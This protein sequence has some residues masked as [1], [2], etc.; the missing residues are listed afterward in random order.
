M[1][2]GSM[3]FIRKF[4][5]SYIL[6]LIL[7]LACFS[8]FYFSY[9]LKIY[10]KNVRRQA[11]DAL[12]TV[13]DELQRTV[14]EFRMI[15][16]QDSGLACTRSAYLNSDMRSEE[17]FALLGRELASH[18]Y[19]ADIT[20]YNTSVPERAY[21]VSGSYEQAYYPAFKHYEENGVDGLERF[22]SGWDAPGW[23][24]AKK[25][26][27][28]D[29]FFLDY[30]VPMSANG[31][32]HIWI[33][34]W[35]TERLQK[36]LESENARTAF[37]DSQDQCLYTTEVEEGLTA[38]IEIRAVSADGEIHLVR[39][40]D[41]KWLFA[42]VAESRNI[43]FSVILLTLLVGS[44]LA[45]FFSMRSSR[46]MEQMEKDILRLEELRR[47]DRLLMELL[48][49]TDG[50]SSDILV[51]L[52]K[53]HMFLKAECYY[54][55]LADILKRPEGEGQE[56]IGERL[57]V[58]ARGPWEL[59]FNG[60]FGE[61]LLVG[62][63]GAVG[64]EADPAPF[65]RETEEEIRKET[66][67]SLAIQAKGPCGTLADIHG[68]Y[69]DAMRM[70]GENTLKEGYFLYPELEMKALYDA[71]LNNE[72]A[73]AG[74]AAD[75]LLERIRDCRQDSFVHSVLC[76]DV[77]R[78]FG[79]TAKKMGLKEEN[80]D[81]LPDWS[82]IS[83]A[84][85][86]GCLPELVKKAWEWT[87]GRLAAQEAESRG[88]R[89]AA[90]VAN[91]IEAHVTEPEISVNQIADQ[92]RMSASNLSHQFKLQTDQN[93]SDYLME[94]KFEYA[95]KLLAK[96]DANVS[97]VAEAIGYIHSGSFI[98]RFRRIYGM[99]PLEYR[100]RCREKDCTPPV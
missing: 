19:L 78:L 44:S 91:Y 7:P 6:L 40:L 57:R 23:F 98:R 13:T 58:L 86:A 11:E 26:G 37:F 51:S 75:A 59:R 9:Y 29:D 77:L 12:F 30:I 25:D 61:N 39:T 42:E 41:E 18:V 53:E 55:A 33:F 21:T 27:R 5:I 8:L 99:T 10:R 67:L 68:L 14:E 92:Y 46:P 36:L 79:Q 100:Q 72:R 81:G 80:G 89:L 74:L 96:T 60:S 83:E 97:S 90:S 28:Q 1:D 16:A 15:A 65:L 50:A 87:V 49:R 85:R 71:V 70:K 76:Y 24:M 17:L 63:L 32:R 38:G 35:D 62:V 52:Q 93:L 66:G 95:R 94:R 64:W 69:L 88:Y 31:E 45:V 43:F 34:R 48:Y 54:V 56:F 22:L 82:A 4:M 84:A 20:Y 73:A 3:C 47:Q 2:R